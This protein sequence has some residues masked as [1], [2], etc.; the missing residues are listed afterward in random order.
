MIESFQISQLLHWK[1]STIV[2][3]RRKNHFACFIICTNTI[4]IDLNG[5]QGLTMM[6]T[7]I[8]ENWKNFCD[9]LTVQNRSLLVS[10]SNLFFS[11]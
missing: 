6:F 1:E 5:L 3:H 11:I 10:R 7:L 8:Q 4:S 9:P 2:T